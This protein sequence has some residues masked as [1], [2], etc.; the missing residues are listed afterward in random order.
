MAEKKKKKILLMGYYGF[1]NIGDEAVLEAIVC[2]LRRY[3]PECELWALSA[4]PAESEAAYGIR[5]FDRW[6]PLQL[7]RALWGC[8]VFAA[9][10]GSLL[11]DVTGARGIKYYL[12]LMRIA[13]LLRKKLFF[14]AQGI[15]PIEDAKNRKLTARVLR[16][17]D[18]LTVRDA[19]AAQYMRELGIDGERIDVACDPVLA[20][21]AEGPEAELPA[22]RKMGFA[23]RDCKGL[24]ADTLARVADHFADKGW[25]I[26]FLPFCS[27]VDTAVSRLI[28]GQMQQK[29]Y[30]AA[31]ITHPR[32]MMKAISACDFV[33]GVRLHALV[34]AAAC[35]VPFA[36]LSYDPKI[37][38]FCHMLDSEPAAAASEQSAPLMVRGIEEALARADELKKRLK[39]EKA[40]WQELAAA[41]ALLLGEC[42]RGNRQADMRQLMK[43]RG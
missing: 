9:G 26:V 41:N 20:M 10:G 3:V 16:K 6:N 8:D 1:D 18:R 39:E 13:K 17:C 22:G 14:Y 24:N 33:V 32:E 29:S 2:Q 27:P 31:Q 35:G 25:E 28:A 34:M 36:A 15:G 43:Q 21:S 19:D 23:V 4:K 5:C 11:Q 7:L 38:G 37:D 40:H 30:I 42:A 12:G